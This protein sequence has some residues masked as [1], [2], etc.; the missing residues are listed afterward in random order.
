MGIFFRYIRDYFKADF[1]LSTHVV[2]AL[3][4]GIAIAINYYY[5]FYDNLTAKYYTQPASVFVVWC[6]YSF[7]FLSATTLISLFQQENKL[8][9]NKK[10]ILFGLLG[11]IFLSLDTSYYLLQFTRWFLPENQYISHWLKACLSN[12]SSLIT[13][14]IP[15]YIIY[16]VFA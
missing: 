15:L 6:F 13:V 9:F 7:A 2:L 4:L 8:I 1:K 12:F 10:F 14:I 16:L 3:F 5:N 11:I